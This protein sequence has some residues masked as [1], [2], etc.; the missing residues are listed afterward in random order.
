VRYDNETDKGDHRHV[1]PNEVV[2][3]YAFSSLRKLLSDF[4]RDIE[5]LSG[6]IK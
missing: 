1:G 4:G 3:R 6:E 5:E 2:S